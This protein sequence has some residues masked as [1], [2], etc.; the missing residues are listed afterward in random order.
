MQYLFQCSCLVASEQAR[1]P[2]EVDVIVS[3]CHPGYVELSPS[4]H[5]L[6]VREKASAYL[7]DLQTRQRTDVSNQPF[8]N[9]LTDD[10]WF[11]EGGIEDYIIDRTTGTQ[12][13]I[14]IFRFWQDNAYV[15]GEPNLE[16]LISALHQA[17]QVFF[18]QRNNDKVIV[19]MSDFRTNP[20]QSFT[21]SRS[22]IPT[23]EFNNRVRQ[24]LRENSVTYQMVLED[25]PHEVVSPDRRFIARDDGIYLAETNQM[26]VKAP[27][28]L[29]RGW[30]ND[31]RGVI[32][33]SNRCLFR[34][35][36]PGIDTG[37]LRMVPQSV[38]KLNV[39]EEY[40]L[41]AQTP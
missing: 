16:L 26:I 6:Y 14:K 38:I 25:F 41:P 3:A 18:T 35:S 12:Y 1:Y 11:I 32:F 4:G 28:S 39:P 19:L 7:L 20:E 2:Q 9:F 30:T 37:C 29:V 36:L 40:L 24:F 5:L 13:P 15:N 27:T 31:G 10:L 17:E 22:D 23:G 21:F 33:A 8:S 34:I